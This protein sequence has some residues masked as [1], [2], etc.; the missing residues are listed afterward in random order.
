MILYRNVAVHISWACSVLVA[1]FRSKVQ[2][3]YKTK[4]QFTCCM[5]CEDFHLLLS[6]QTIQ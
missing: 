3:K 1:E 4:R 6:N 5:V 2:V